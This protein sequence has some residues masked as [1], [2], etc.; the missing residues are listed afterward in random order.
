MEVIIDS[1]AAMHIVIPYTILVDA[2]DAEEICLQRGLIHYIFYSVPIYYDVVVWSPQNRYVGAGEIAIFGAH[3]RSIAKSAV[4]YVHPILF[5][6]TL[7]LWYFLEELPDRWVVWVEHRMNAA[8]TGCIDIF[9][10]LWKM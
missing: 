1:N 2:C 8:L 3:A 9:R 10:I 7:K 6:I 5:L 4:F